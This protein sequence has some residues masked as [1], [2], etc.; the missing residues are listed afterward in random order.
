MQRDVDGAS[1]CGESGCAYHPSLTSKFAE[2]KQDIGREY[3]TTCSV[4]ELVL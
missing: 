3:D 2:Q 4:R 1:G